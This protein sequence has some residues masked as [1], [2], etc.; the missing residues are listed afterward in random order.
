[1]RDVYFSPSARRSSTSFAISAIGLDVGV[2]G[3]RDQHTAADGVLHLARRPIDDDLQP[4]EVL[5]VGARVDDRRAALDARGLDRHVIVR[6][7][8]HVDPGDVT[9]ELHRVD[10]ADVRGDDDDVGLLLHLG[11]QRAD[12]VGGGLELEPGHA[13]RLHDRRRAWVR[14]P[15]DPDARDPEILHHERLQVGRRLAGLG[16]DDVRREER[17][18]R[19]LRALGEHVLPPVELVVARPRAR[20]SASGSSPS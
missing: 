15:D 10:Q 11:D 2:G 6:R 19:L 9:R 7:D 12:R 3:D 5:G 20:H 13:R 18:R 16:L 17:E 4:T 8:D 1:M 14:E